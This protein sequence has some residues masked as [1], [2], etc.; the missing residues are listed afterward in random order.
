MRLILSL[1]VVALTLGT[2][3]CGNKDKA[4]VKERGN[5]NKADYDAVSKL[6]EMLTDGADAMDMALK[7]DGSAIN[8]VSAAI[9]PL[10]SSKATKV[11]EA[12]Q[13]ARRS[14]ACRVSVYQEPSSKFENPWSAEQR[15]E[16][17]ACPVFSVR[18][19]QWEYNPAKS[20]EQMWMNHSFTVKPSY[21]DYV[22]AIGIKEVT[23]A[24]GRINV[25]RQASTG[26]TRI[27]GGFAYNQI[28]LASGERLRATIS[29]AQDYSG[30][31]GKGS[32]RV[33]LSS[34]NW[35]AVGEITWPGNDFSDRKYTAGGGAISHENFLKLFS[36]FRLDEIVDNSER[37]R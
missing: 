29:T 32:A 30:S 10:I 4:K 26:V 28:Q 14:G 20:I 15:L 33:I 11:G 3:A 27:N 7:S 25:T 23:S 9:Q 12:L 19:W 16:G 31:S 22:N 2:L 37:M 36:F 35:Q 34:G 13:S 24:R 8:P 21:K 1:V 17:S 18:S 6:N 5:L